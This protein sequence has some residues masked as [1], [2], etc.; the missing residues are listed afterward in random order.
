MRRDAQASFP[1]SVCSCKR[2]LAPRRRQPQELQ[3]AS[4]RATQKRVRCGRRSLEIRR[5]GG[6]VERRKRGKRQR[7]ARRRR[8]LKRWSGGDE[9]IAAF[10]HRLH[11]RMR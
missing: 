1:V 10:G 3:S 4:T 2:L 7:R 9:K 8:R 6:K 5:R 11:V